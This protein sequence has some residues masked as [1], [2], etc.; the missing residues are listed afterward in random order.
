MN[1]KLHTNY[2]FSYIFSFCKYVIVFFCAYF[3]LLPTSN[4]NSPYLE[5]T[6]KPLYFVIPSASGVANHIDLVYQVRVVNISA[7][8]TLFN[9]K[10]EDQLSFFFGN[11]FKGMTAIGMPKIIYTN[12]KEVPTLNTSFNGNAYTQFFSISQPTNTFLPGQEIVLEFGIELNQLLLPYNAMFQNQLFAAAKYGTYGGPTTTDLSDGGQ[13]AL[14]D[15]GGS[16]DP[17]FNYQPPQFFAL[18]SNGSAELNFGGNVSEYTDWLNSYGNVIVSPNAFPCSTLTWTNDEATAVWVNDCGLAAH[19]DVTFTLADNCD[20]RMSFKARFTKVDTYPPTLQGYPQNKT[21][22]CADPNAL[23]QLNTWLNG[24]GASATDMNGPVTISTNFTG[25]SLN[26]GANITVKF[27]F[28]DICNNTTTDKAQL[29]IIDNVPPTITQPAKNKNVPC[30]TTQNIN[31]IFQAWLANNGGAKAIDACSNAVQWTSSPTTPT[32]QNNSATVTFNAKDLC[33][34]TSITMASFTVSDKKAPTVT[35]V[36][37]AVTVTCPDAMVFGAPIFKDNC[38]PNPVITSKD[39]IWGNPCPKANFHQRFWTAKDNVG[40]ATTVSQL[41]TVNELLI[42]TNTKMELLQSPTNVILSCGETVK[43]DSTIL[44]KTTCPNKN[45][46][47]TYKDST[48]NDAC[49]FGYKLWKRTWTATDLCQ[50]K[51]ITSQTFTQEAD[52]KAPVFD[53]IPKNLTLSCNQ[54]LVWGIPLVSDNCTPLN[55]LVI[56][57]Q[58]E[59]L[60]QFACKGSQSYR[61]TW[62]VT[63]ACGNSN[64]AS[65]ILTFEDKTPPYF[66]VVLDHKIINCNDLIIFDKATVQDACGGVYLNYQEQIL[67]GTC[68]GNYNV[69]RTWTATDECGNANSSNQIITVKDVQKPVFDYIPPS[70]TL[71]CGALL[72]L[73]TATAKDN[74]GTPTITYMDF[75]ATPDCKKTPYSITRIWKATDACGNAATASQ[76]VSTEIDSIAPVLEMALPLEKT[77]ECLDLNPIFD[78]PI[79]KDN[80]SKVTIVQKDTTLVEGCEHRFQRQWT[81]TDACGNQQTTKQTIISGLDTSAPKANGM[82]QDK[83]LLCGESNTEFDTLIFSD[84]CPDF[85]TIFKDSIVFKNCEETKY[86]YWTA[87]DPCGNTT[88]VAQKITIID[89]KIPVFDQVLPDTLYLTNYEFMDWQIPILGAKDACSAIK[90][91][92]QDD[93][94][95]KKDCAQQSYQYKWTAIDVCGNIAKKTLYVQVIDRDLEATFSVPSPLKN[96]TTIPLKATVKGG[97]TPYQYQWEIE[98]YDKGT[99]YWSISDDKSD[100]TTLKVGFGGITLYLTVTDSNNCVVKKMARTSNIPY[101]NAFQLFPTLAAREMTLIYNA[102]EENRAIEIEIIDL[103]GRAVQKWEEKSKMGLN[104]T[105]ISVE[106]LQSN[107]YLLRIKQEGE[108][109]FME[110]FI[111]I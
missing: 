11:A 96:H 54:N 36:P 21:I 47:I 76:T 44:V 42:P 18:P 61:R 39:T 20:A 50:N 95:D 37:A 92:F 63:D 16:D 23:T 10:L 3:F 86:R 68:G 27:F 66:T 88:K 110:K 70:Q 33:G 90:F 107:T 7:T 98:N 94:K 80:C 24:G 106:N 34:N 14:G 12:A 103:V 31:T 100:L 1:R 2:H 56:D 69:V 35:F 28:K 64:S 60:N 84:N 67:P 4:A 6:A 78:T 32:L 52:N 79:F 17:T 48:Y 65:Q 25:L 85:K 51:V 81:A 111:K 38:D 45:I 43:F 99:R 19:K 29:T 46:T 91:Q 93:P 105:N 89:N 41:I 22:N 59:L 30:D 109:I 77:S 58:E 75:N 13:G 62:T 101:K 87:S 5:V 97:K 71:S 104:K 9:V 40:N 49:K 102:E 73:G 74:C 55:S 53:Y 108:I 82:L 83:Q 26:C 15:T 8:S 57:Q 72:Q